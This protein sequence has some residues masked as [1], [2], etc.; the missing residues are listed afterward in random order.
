MSVY[1]QTVITSRP[2]TVTRSE[3]N[4]TNSLRSVTARLVPLLRS[5]GC[6][7]SAALLDCNQ[8]AKAHRENGAPRLLVLAFSD[9][10]GPE[11]AVLARAS[12]MA[13]IVSMKDAHHK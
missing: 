7:R 6:E 12:N 3:R 2:Q 5:A 8:P 10:T 11:R 1:G 9:K 13:E 4:L